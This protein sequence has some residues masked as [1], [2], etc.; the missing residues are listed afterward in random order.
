MRPRHPPG[1]VPARHA[2]DWLITYAD[3]IT[4]LLC[5]L[6]VLLGLH[7]A[8]PHVARLAQSPPAAAAP[9]APA[10][11]PPPIV[12]A[13]SSGPAGAQPS[14]QSMQPSVQATLAEADNQAPNRDTAWP[15]RASAEVHAR[16]ATPAV[17]RTVTASQASAATPDPDIAAFVDLRENAH[18]GRV[19]A[20]RKD[21][22]ARAAGPAPN[23]PD[24]PA[25]RTMESADETESAGETRQGSTEKT[26]QPGEPANSDAPLSGPPAAARSP[27]QP[28]A[29]DTAQPNTERHVAADEPPGDRIT[30]FQCSDAAFFASGS[31]VL[32]DAG[33]D[34]LTRLL[35]TLQSS[36]LA[37]YR[38]TVEGHTDDEPITQPQY[39][40][41]WELSSAR[42]AAVVRF[43]VGHGIAAQR[44]RAAGYADTRPLAPNR[45]AAGNPLPQNQARNRRVVVELEKIDHKPNE[46]RR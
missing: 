44:L 41:N 7:G 11:P 36:R 23:A 14:A 2:D 13:P 43:F 22:A 16:P 6:V 8:G 15:G 45:D 24:A 18:P 20:V 34:I 9:P 39:P 35:V 1:A 10:F 40:S 12:V 3:T 38:I 21:D 29:P 5:V 31:A 17:L 32:S 28:P 30:I 25:P 46:A 27:A 33:Q 26:W 19:Q 37:D 4:L 42:A